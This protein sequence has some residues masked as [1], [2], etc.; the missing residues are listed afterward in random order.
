[1]CVYESQ[2]D[3][4][5]DREYRRRQGDGLGGVWL[6]ETCPGRV[7]YFARGVLYEVRFDLLDRQVGGVANLHDMT[8]NASRDLLARLS[9]LYVLVRPDDVF[10]CRDLVRLVSHAKFRVDVIAAALSAVRASGE[11]ERKPGGGGGGPRGHG[12]PIHARM[13]VQAEDRKPSEEVNTRRLAKALSGVPS[14]ETA[15][16]A[17]VAIYSGAQCQRPVPQ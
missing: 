13:L 11:Q 7:N 17:R 3:A 8:F 4:D 10:P 6:Y 2:A 9:V 15:Q 16:E 14:S 1:M 12:S 5:H